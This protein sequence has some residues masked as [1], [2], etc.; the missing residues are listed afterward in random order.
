MHVTINVPRVLQAMHDRNWH[1]R[2][3]CSACHI[4]SRTL[5]KVL[6]GEMPQRLDAW[7]RLCNGLGLRDEEVLRDAAT[8]S[9]EKQSSV[10]SRRRPA[11][12]AEN[13][14]ADAS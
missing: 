14:K 13:G 12:V 11:E 7:Y 4:N 2:E 5:Q 6:A 9:L 3:T 8:H 10:S 1:I